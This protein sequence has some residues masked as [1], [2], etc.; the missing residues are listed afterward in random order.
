MIL[1]GL[2]SLEFVNFDGTNA[3][4]EEELEWATPEILATEPESMP[5]TI[6]ATTGYLKLDSQSIGFELDTGEKIK[7]ES[8]EKAREE[9]W[10]EWEK[11][12]PS[13]KC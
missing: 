7:F 9:Y 10:D 5:I 4:L 3:S 1:S 13:V 2:A 6:A 12:N 11:R 8:I